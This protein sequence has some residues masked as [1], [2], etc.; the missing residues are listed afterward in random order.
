[1]SGD[2]TGLLTAFEPSAARGIGLARAANADLRS[3]LAHIA[4]GIR[5]DLPASA[6]RITSFLSRTGENLLPPEAFATYYAL[7]FAA[8]AEDAGIIEAQAARLDT[9][10]TIPNGW[11]IF[12]RGAAGLLDTALDERPGEGE[13]FAALP[14]DKADAFGP[15]LT[16]GRQLLA[17]AAPELSGE[18]EAIVNTVILAQAPEGATFEFDGASHYQ[19]WGL[20][21]LN[22]KHHRTRLAVAEVLAHEAGHSLLFGLTTQEPLVRNPDEELYSSPLRVDPRPMDGIFHATFVSARMAWAMERIAASDALDG[23]ERAE[24]RRAAEL[25]RENFAKGYGTVQEHGDLTDTGR[26]IITAAADWIALR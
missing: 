16:A 17:D 3:S 26:A 7:A 8:I 4:D 22:P 13:T 25:D 12:P 18:I 15:L 14:Q 6:D 20:L 19:F 9:V 23:N 21:L 5:D 1:M 11:R 24:A 10:Q 2:L